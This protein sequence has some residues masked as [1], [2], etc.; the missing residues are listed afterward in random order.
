MVDIIADIVQ[1]SLLSESAI[2][3]ERSV[4]MQEAA[5]VNKQPEEVVLDHLHATAFQKS[6]LGHTILGPMSNIRKMTRDHILEYIKTHY[7]AP[8][9]VLVGTGN[10]DHMDLVRQAEQA[11]KHLPSSGATRD[12]LLAA[13]N[14]YFTGSDVRIREP[15]MDTCNFA[16]AFEGLPH[17]HPDLPALMVL[18][19]MIGEFNESSS[20]DHHKGSQ[21]ASQLSFAGLAKNMFSFCTPYH[22]TGIFGVYCSAKEEH[23]YHA[24]VAVRPRLLLPRP[25]ASTQRCA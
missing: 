23:I 19:R 7:T 2:E 20:T 18:Q 6:P 13:Q 17:T 1:N 10:I 25:H 8:R 21:L 3:R 5:E 4:I 24:C 15:D 9:M 12:E 14:P 11:F 22:D 16:I